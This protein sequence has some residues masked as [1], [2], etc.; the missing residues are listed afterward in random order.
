V[1]PFAKKEE[2]GFKKKKGDVG[3]A[4]PNSLACSLFYTGSI[5]FTANLV[6]FYLKL[7]PMATIFL[8][9]LKNERADIVKTER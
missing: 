3:T 9:V 8:P 1:P 4:L 6:L 7:R 5:H 2:V